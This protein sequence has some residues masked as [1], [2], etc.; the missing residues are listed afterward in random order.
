MLTDTNVLLRFLKTTDKMHPVVANAVTH[1]QSIGVD[2]IIVPQNL[3]EFW[4]VATRPVKV[5]GFGWT[6]PET[7]LRIGRL[8]RVFRFLPDPADH[9]DT[10]E[11]L[12]FQNACHGKVAHD[13]RLVAAME[14]HGVGAI[15]TFNVTDFTRFPGITVLDPAMVAP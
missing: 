6:V 14:L 10:W 9:F 1:L 12:I 15:L 4:V 5:N 2:I 11:Q 8:E 13:A 7:R 3:Y